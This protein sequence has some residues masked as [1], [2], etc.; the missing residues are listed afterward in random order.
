MQVIQRRSPTRIDLGHKRFR[1]IVITLDP[2]P[3][4]GITLIVGSYGP[5]DDLIGSIEARRK[6][7]KT[8]REYWGSRRV[9]LDKYASTAACNPWADGSARRP[10]AGS[11]ISRIDFLEIGHPRLGEIRRSRYVQISVAVQ[12]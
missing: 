8:G 10:D 9:E 1:I 12:C 3:D 6:S 5:R 7:G 2:A 11:R 4:I